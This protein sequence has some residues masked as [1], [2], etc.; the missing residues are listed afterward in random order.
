MTGLP[1]RGGRRPVLVWI[2]GGGFD[3]GS[4]APPVTDGA[5]LSRLT[6]AVVVAAN[7]RLGPLGYLHLADLGGE[8]WADRTNWAC[9]LRTG[10]SGRLLGR[11][12]SPA[13]RTP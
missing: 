3:S 4:A 8:D 5:A 10:V 13:W 7:Y 6:G 1:D 12:R 2:Y 11:H 9:W